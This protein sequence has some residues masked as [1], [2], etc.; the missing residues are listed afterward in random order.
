MNI[1]HINIETQMT[2]MTEK[3]VYI[4]D[5]FLVMSRTEG[6]NSEKN[7]HKIENSDQNEQ[8]P[9]KRVTPIFT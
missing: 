8:C 2:E 5:P 7:D 6:P 1:F 3:M 4:G 9:I